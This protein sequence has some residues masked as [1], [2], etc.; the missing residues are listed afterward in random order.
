M[1]KTKTTRLTDRQV[2][3]AFEQTHDT[4]VATARPEHGWGTRTINI[5]TGARR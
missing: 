2:N 5:R 3:A 4:I 1:K